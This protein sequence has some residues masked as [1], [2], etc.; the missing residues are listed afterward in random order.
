M[1]MNKN[2]IANIIIVVLGIIALGVM[3]VLL[4]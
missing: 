2:T 1:K 3:Y 4:V